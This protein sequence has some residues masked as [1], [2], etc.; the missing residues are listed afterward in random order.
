MKITSG[1]SPM[2]FASVIEEA[3]AWLA[4]RLRVRS[5]GYLTWLLQRRKQ[6]PLPAVQL[7]AKLCSPHDNLINSDPDMYPGNGERDR[8]RSLCG[9]QLVQPRASRLRVESETKPCSKQG[10]NGDV[11]EA[12]LLP[13]ISQAAIAALL[14][15]VLSVQRSMNRFRSGSK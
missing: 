2:R 1:M 9:R 3:I 5:R 12:E 11:L 6:K 8:E 7:Q 13:L 15:A 4:E 14:A 10:T